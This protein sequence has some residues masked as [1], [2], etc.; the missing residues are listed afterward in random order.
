MTDPDQ[1][2]LVEFTREFFG[3]AEF[4]SVEQAERIVAFMGDKS[5]ELLGP[6]KVA[7]KQRALAYIASQKPDP[8]EGATVPLQTGDR[9]S[10]GQ[11]RARK[12]D[13][14]TSH[15]AAKSISEEAIA[16][17]QIEVLHYLRAMHRSGV[18]GSTDEDVVE[19]STGAFSHSRLRT[20]RA[21]LVV[22]GM[23]QR[24]GQGKTSRGRVCQKWANTPKGIAALQKLEG[25]A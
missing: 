19:S 3:G 23:V 4:Y 5:D 2:D 25:R 15:A 1:I 22:M 21:E 14:A 8:E 9:G 17:S 12:T 20:A 6:E 24:A 16:E 10:T 7:R 18:S 11:A 13:P